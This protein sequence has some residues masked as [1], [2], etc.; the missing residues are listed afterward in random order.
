MNLMTEP[1]M[2]LIANAGSSWCGVVRPIM[3]AFRASD[4]G[5]NPGTST[6]DK[7]YAVQRFLGAHENPS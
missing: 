3:L 5:S 4:P 6:F 2:W 7:W 1:I